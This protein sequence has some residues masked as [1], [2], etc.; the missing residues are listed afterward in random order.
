MSWERE[1]PGKERGARGGEAGDG[2]R[3]GGWLEVSEGFAR[4]PPPSSGQG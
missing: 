2:H 3:G 1:W 4:Q